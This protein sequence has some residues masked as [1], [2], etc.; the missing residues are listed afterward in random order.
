M[1]PRVVAR[2]VKNKERADGRRE[3]KGEGE[4][5]VDM[6]FLR[7]GVNSK[8]GNIPLC[9]AASIGRKSWCAPA[10]ATELL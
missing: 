3:G 1:N 4:E 10:D 6:E 7:G 9:L 2:P 5:E 8:T